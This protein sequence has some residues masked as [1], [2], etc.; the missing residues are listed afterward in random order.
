MFGDIYRNFLNIY[1]KKMFYFLQYVNNMAEIV[2]FSL[3]P[4]V[5][6]PYLPLDYGLNNIT[7]IL[8]QGCL[9]H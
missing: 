4:G 8:L 1:I 3:V 7:I 9:C 6:P 5:G 2:I